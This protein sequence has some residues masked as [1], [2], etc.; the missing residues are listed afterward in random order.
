MSLRPHPEVRPAAMPHTGQLSAEAA[1]KVVE[2]FAGLTT[3]H[4]PKQEYPMAHA[5]LGEHA[6]ADKT[7][8]PSIPASDFAGSLPP[9]WHDMPGLVDDAHIDADSQ[10]RIIGLVDETGSVSLGDII[11]ALPDHP[12]PAKAVLSLVRHGILNI[13]P[14]LVTGHTMVRRHAALPFSGLTELKLSGGQEAPP[15]GNKRA[16]HFAP[17]RPQPELFIAHWTDRAT[18]RREAALQAPGIYIALYADRAYVG[19]SGQLRE[20][21]VASNH[22]LAHGFPDLVVAMVDKSGIMSQAQFRVAERLLARAVQRDGR[23]HLANKTLPAGAEVNIAA[24]AA[25]DRFVRDA[26]TAIREADIG[27]LPESRPADSEHEVLESGVS[28]LGQDED[29]GELIDGELLSLRSCGIHATARRL[30]DKIHVLAGSEV[31]R[32][33]VPSIKSGVILQRQELQHDGGL[34]AH[35]ANL[36][37]TRDVAFDTASGAA[38]FVTGSRLKPEIWRPLRQNM[39]SGLLH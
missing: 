18:F 14:G 29:A 31:R 9:R 24:F 6:L 4:L 13:D 12:G 30:G 28:D 3:G 38:S 36:M 25:A 15:P 7:P 17:S 37:L 33:T 34:V 1:D 27:F 2:H 11:A 21:V 8:S 39:P 22:L 32:T 19:M 16:N 5:I 26:I 10:V 35:G 20:R 23:L